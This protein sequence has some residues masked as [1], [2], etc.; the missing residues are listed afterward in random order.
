MHDMQTK[1]KE[2]HLDRRDLGR[3]GLRG[4][5]KQ[6]QRQRKRDEGAARRRHH[7]QSSRA[8]AAAARAVGQQSRHVVVDQEGFFLGQGTLWEKS[9]F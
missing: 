7:P 8:V 1:A 9:F 6:R 5:A 2:Q 4:G 3:R